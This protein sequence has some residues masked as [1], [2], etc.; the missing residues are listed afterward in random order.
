MLSFSSKQNLTQKT[1]N[2]LCKLVGHNWRYKDYSNWMKE[3]GDSYDFKASRNCIRCS[4]KEYL[5][6]YWKIS[7]RKS[8]YDMERDSYSLK[9]LPYLQTH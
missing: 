2:T 6:E 1:L 4:Q 5:Y 8:P 9:Q 3:N 7:N